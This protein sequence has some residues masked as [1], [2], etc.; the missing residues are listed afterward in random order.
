MNGLVDCRN[1]STFPTD[2][3]VPAS[4]NCDLKQVPEKIKSRMKLPQSKS[5]IMI[6]SR[7][8]HIVPRSKSASI[9]LMPKTSS[10][11][12]DSNSCTALLPKT[13]VRKYANSTTNKMSKSF[14]VTSSNDLDKLKNLQLNPPSCHNSKERKVTL[15]S[16]NFFF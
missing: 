9:P 5:D 10:K 14:A 8:S 4:E 16:G 3:V 2:K 13:S 7:R 15:S 1:L 12:C 6:N 11:T